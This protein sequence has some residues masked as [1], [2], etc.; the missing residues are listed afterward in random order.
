MQPKLFLRTLSL[1]HYFLCAGLIAFG[2]FAYWQNGSFNAGTIGEDI[3][4]YIVPIV[5]MM[6]YFGSKLMYRKMILNLP[7]NETLATKLSRYQVANL[8]QYALLEGPAFLALFVYLS[9]GTALYLAIAIAL[10]IYLFARRPTLN[11]LFEEVPMSFEEKKQ[12]DT[13]RS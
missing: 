13:L 7:K 6:G 4:V 10:T 8:V 5:A 9:S 1:I 2:A 3:F 11:R 12:F